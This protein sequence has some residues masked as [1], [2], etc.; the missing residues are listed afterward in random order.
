MS[1]GKPKPW[2]F[3]ALA[4]TVL[5]GAWGA[6]IEIPEQAGF[7][8]TLSYVTWSV[9]LIPVSI[10]ALFRIN[11]ELDSDLKSI[12]FGM[13]AGLL[14]SGGQLILF[15][16]LISSPAYLFFP[17]ISLNP[18]ITIL[19]SVLI[20]KERASKLAWVGIFLALCAILM[21]SY[22]EPDA[23]GNTNYAW[24]LVAL[25]ISAMWGTQ[26]FIIKY[27]SSV[28]EVGSMKAESI[29]FYCMASSITLLPVA[30]F[31]TDFSL[32]INWGLT[33][34]YSA[35]VIQSLNAVGFLFF[36]LALRFGK[37][38]IVVPLMNASAPVVTVILSLMIYALI[39][40]A[41]I[42]TGMIVAFVAIYF[43]TREEA[44]LEEGPIEEGF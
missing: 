44:A 37:A 2:L 7:P 41:I 9:I 5:W 4:V 19:L 29:V 20:I 18:A 10:Y 15:Q 35:V 43:M 22:Q 24:L 17:I 16:A 6:L 21:L 8:A 32:D 1:F 3:Y 27:A 23:Y 26:A 36:A 38:I 34:M 39:P 28:N 12:F 14:G 30:L 25:L 42:L 13:T 11:W 40:H 31:M 33:G